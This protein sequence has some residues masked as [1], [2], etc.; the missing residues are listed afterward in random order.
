MVLCRNPFAQPLAALGLLLALWGTVQARQD[1]DWHPALTAGLGLG[2]AG[3]SAIPTWIILPA[4]ILYLL[5]SSIPHRDSLRPTLL[6]ITALL[7][8]AGAFA[9]GQATYNLLRFGSPL[10]TG[11]QQLGVAS[12]RL[13]YFG[14]AL[15]G[16]YSAHLAGSSGMLLL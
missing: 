1:S 11:Y 10:Q 2:L 9:L 5:P 12:F 4:H 8:G 3:L 6:P 14:T 16:N 15:S 13:A 7:S